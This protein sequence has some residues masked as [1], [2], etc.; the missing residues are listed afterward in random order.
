M[1]EGTTNRA[2]LA[3]QICQQIAVP[4]QDAESLVRSIISLI[5]EALL[6]GETVKLAG[7]GV[8]SV[9]ER[10]E[11]LGRNITA[12]STVLIPKRHVVVFKPSNKLKTRVETG[13]ADRL[14]LTK[15]QSSPLFNVV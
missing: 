10:K 13:A 14:R 4:C 5:E 7:F 12:G 1:G 3:E 11:M 2:D 6:S 15:L 9:V 8:F